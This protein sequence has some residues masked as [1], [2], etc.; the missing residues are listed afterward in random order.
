MDLGEKLKYYQTNIDKQKSDISCLYND[1]SAELKGNQLN[2]EKSSPIKIEHFL[3]Y[4]HFLPHAFQEDDPLIF[5]PLLSRGQFTSKLN[6]QNILI[7]D[8]ETTGLAGG[9]GTYPFLIGFGIFEKEGIRLYQ[10]FLPDYGME[11]AAFLDIRHLTEKRNIILSYNGKS[12]DYPLLR[13]RYILNRLDNPFV[14]Y[15]HLDLLHIA[16]RLWKTTLLNC[17]LENVE[18]EVFLFERWEDIES[19]SIPFAYF[20]FLRN[21]AIQQIKKI[22]THNQQDLISLARLL[23]HFNRK[24]NAWLDDQTS[25]QELQ[26]LC[27]L[28]IHTINLE[29]ADYY[30]EEINTREIAMMPELLAAF[31]LLLKR[32]GKWYRAEKIWLNFINSGCNILFAHEELAKYYE[33]RKKDLFQAKLH[34][35]QALKYITIIDEINEQEQKSDEGN[36]FERRLGR[37]NKKIVA[38][39]IIVD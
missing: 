34:T 8:L 10:Y 37:L 35:E 25:Q 30:L 17:S 12:F 24:E 38:S 4:H 23:F 14:H 18:R 13:N 22:L 1:L 28:A 5:I 33:H 3:P 20:E 31:S 26:M 19:S 29:R 7:F 21:G 27:K 11:A 39:R 16:R 6:L 2:S 32:K 9:T 36:K 15:D